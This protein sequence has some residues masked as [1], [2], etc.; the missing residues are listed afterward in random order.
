MTGGVFGSG[1]GKGEDGLVFIWGG[2][3]GVLISWHLKLQSH[4][5]FKILV[6]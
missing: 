1:E 4:W 3:G 5:V 6:M 2:S